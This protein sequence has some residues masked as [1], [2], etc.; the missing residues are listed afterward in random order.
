[1]TSIITGLLLL[2][3][4]PIVQISNAATIEV[5][6]YGIDELMPEEGLV[7]IG[8]RMI[9]YPDGQTKIEVPY[10]DEDKK[11]WINVEA[12]EICVQG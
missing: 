7:P 3:L 2:T 8:T 12:Y 1:M 11:A 6:K 5:P 4:V 9:E 10:K